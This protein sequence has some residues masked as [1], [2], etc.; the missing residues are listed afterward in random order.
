MSDYMKNEYSERFDELRKNRVEVSYHKYGPVKKNFST[1]NVQA[2]PTMQLCVDKY[3]ETGNTEYLLDA[4]NYLMFEFMYPQHKKA[5]F[6]A[7]DSKDSA[8]IV[9]ISEKEMERY[10]EDGWK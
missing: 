6:K 10:R 7:T 4:A 5:H 2:I 8:G 3:N 1:G 9:G